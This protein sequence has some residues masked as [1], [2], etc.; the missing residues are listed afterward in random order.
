MIILF[1]CESFLVFTLLFRWESHFL[2]SSYHRNRFPSMLPCS[3]C[4]PYSSPLHLGGFSAWGATDNGISSKLEAANVMRWDIWYFYF[5]T[6]LFC[7][8]PVGRS[9]LGRCILLFKFHI[10]FRCTATR[11]GLQGSQL[12]RKKSQPGVTPAE[13]SQMIYQQSC[14]YIVHH[15]LALLSLLNSIRNLD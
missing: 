8:D 4:N 7:S 2:I 10:F 5:F 3:C 15:L 6:P 11:P 12:E 9:G 13:V 1:A 14:F